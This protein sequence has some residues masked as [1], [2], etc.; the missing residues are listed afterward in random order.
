MHNVAPSLPLP[1]WMCTT[2]TCVYV[3]VCRRQSGEREG[4]LGVPESPG[5]SSWRYSSLSLSSLW[6]IILVLFRQEWDGQCWACDEAPWPLEIHFHPAFI[7]FP[8]SASLHPTLTP[9]HTERLITE[10]WSILKDPS[11]SANYEK[12]PPNMKNSSKRAPEHF[13]SAAG[14]VGTQTEL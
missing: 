7:S 12:A 1:V 3:C 4:E 8:F 10:P 11:L 5:C 13:S 14:E 6:V 9:M 2:I